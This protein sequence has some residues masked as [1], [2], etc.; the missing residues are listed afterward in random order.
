M[1]SI[2]LLN[3]LLSMHLLN[4]DWWFVRSWDMCFVLVLVVPSLSL[5]SLVTFSVS[6]CSVVFSFDRNRLFGPE[7]L[8]ISFEVDDINIHTAFLDGSPLSSD[9]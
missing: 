8:S 5:F 3:L 7:A 6:F 2:G 9:H 1:C 4:I